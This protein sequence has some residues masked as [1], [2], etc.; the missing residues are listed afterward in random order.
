MNSVRGISKAV[1]IDRPNRFLGR[2]LIDGRTTEV[3][4]PNPG[5]MLELMIPGTEVF[6]RE[7]RSAKRKTNYNM[8]GLEYNGVLVSIDSYLP[9]RFVKRLFLEHRLSFF[10][11]YDTVIPEPRAFDG[12]FDFKLIGPEMSA[13]I[14]VKSCT[15]VEN[16][17]AIFPD[18]PTKRG[19]RH[20]RNLAEALNI[21]CVD[22]AA[23]IFVIQRPDASVFSPND[24]TDPVFADALRY[25]HRKG[26][27]VFPLV[28]QVIDWDLQ[29]K[30]IIPF[31]LDYF[32]VKT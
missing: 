28:T 6:V 13:F 29:L 12:R 18:A 15:L 5:R 20:L 16:N 7:K 22:R 8:I 2:V 24:K 19:S 23:V 17:R 9:N 14:E 26:V 25:A 11:N 30:E 3:F 21:K 32:V 4:I 10:D 31:E 1:F 27:E